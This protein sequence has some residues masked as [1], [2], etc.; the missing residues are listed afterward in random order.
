[1]RPWRRSSGLLC[2]VGL[3][4]LRLLKRMLTTV[5]SEPPSRT[6]ASVTA[7][8][9]AG[10]QCSEPDTLRRKYSSLRRAIWF[11]KLTHHNLL[12]GT[13]IAPNIMKFSVAI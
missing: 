6:S 1:M 3:D 8:S 4:K 11:S 7:L 13:Q 9:G 10:R 12:S 5:L 2:S